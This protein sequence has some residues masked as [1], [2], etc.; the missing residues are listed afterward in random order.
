MRLWTMGKSLP[1]IVILMATLT[2]GVGFGEEQ[3]DAHLFNLVV[4]VRRSLLV[5]FRQVQPE[6]LVTCWCERGHA[7]ELM[8]R[9]SADAYMCPKCRFTFKFVGG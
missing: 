8:R 1:S 7:L 2:W 4:A 3:G 5:A 6:P 9:V